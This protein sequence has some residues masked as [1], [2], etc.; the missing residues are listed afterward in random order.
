MK[1][2]VRAFID[3]S[4]K[5]FEDQKSDSLDEK[6]ESIIDAAYK[7]LENLDINTVR[8]W[9]G[10][11]DMGVSVVFDIKKGVKAGLLK[12]F[13]NLLF[14]FGQE[15]RNVRVLHDDLYV[16]KSLPEG[17]SFLRENPVSSSPGVGNY[18]VIDGFAINMRWARY[19]YLAKRILDL[20]LIPKNGVWIDIG[21]F[22]GG[23]QGIVL[24]YRPDVKVVLVDFHHQ[25]LRSHLYLSTCHPTLKHLFPSQVASLGSFDELPCGSVTY[26]PAG[27]FDHIRNFSADF[28]SN[29]FSFGE[30]PRSVLLDYVNSDL[31]RNAQRKYFVNRF[32]SSPYFE[33]TYG[34][35]TNIFDYNIPCESI[36]YFDV[37][38]IHHYHLLKREVFGFS[39]PRNTS[40]CYFELIIKPNS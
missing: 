20:S 5:F 12:P 40:S 24:K 22:Y 21:P 36:A 33:P 9:S 32:V 11:S 3:N 27:D 15:R 8:N 29:F 35:D 17:G 4:P 18:S 23:L 16:L 2:L 34:N 28:V 30:M 19:L 31:I 38:P 10:Q 7:E 14:R 26:V 25:L 13:Y 6:H 1:S 37:F 39:A